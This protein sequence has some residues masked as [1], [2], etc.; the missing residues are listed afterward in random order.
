MCYVVTLDE[1]AELKVTGLPALR[2]KKKQS[3]WKA[4]S[5]SSVSDGPV[6][7]VPVNSCWADRQSFPA[8]I[9]NVFRL[10]VLRIEAEVNEVTATSRL[11]AMCSC[12]SAA[13]SGQLKRDASRTAQN[14]SRPAEMPGR[15]VPSGRPAHRPTALPRSKCQTALLL[16]AA[17][18][19]PG[20]WGGW[21][22][23]V[24]VSVSVLLHQPCCYAPPLCLH[25]ATEHGKARVCR[26]GLGPPQRPLR[27]RVGV[28]PSI[29]I[30]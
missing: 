7:S 25:H 15:F 8:R 28:L 14:G 22:T 21:C 16:L 17:P 13:T 9:P 2:W 1:D 12:F 3:P 6:P 29:F 5:E 26:H 23:D 11:T 18:Q 27:Q 19:G 4:A 20:S 30:D 10:F 24:L